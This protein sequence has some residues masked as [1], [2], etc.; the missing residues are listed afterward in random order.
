MEQENN[1]LRNRFTAWLTKL[2]RRAKIN[3]IEKEKR[4]KNNV[5]IDSVS[6]KALSEDPYYIDKTESAEK[7]EFSDE[8]V[9]KSFSILSVTRQ[10]ILTMIY[11]NDMNPEE[12]AAKLGCSVQNVY[13]QTSIALKQLRKLIGGTK[14]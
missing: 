2:V 4:H 1:E 5:P 10:K 3:Y 8:S 6:E 9:A 14:L 11:L 7:I 13:N 12:I